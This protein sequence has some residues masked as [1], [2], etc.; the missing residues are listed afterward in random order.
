MPRKIAG[1]EFFNENVAICDHVRPGGLKSLE[2]GDR[3]V[4]ELFIDFLSPCSRVV[5]VGCGA[6]FPGLYVA[7][8]IKKLVGVDAAPNMIAAAQRNAAKVGITNVEFLV[9]S[10]DSLRFGNEEFDGALLCGLLESMDW[11]TVHSTVPEVWR[12]LTSGGRLVVLDRDW[13]NVLKRGP[14]RETDILYEK[15]RLV[16][17]L[18][19]LTVSPHMEKDTRYLVD[20][21][22]SLGQRMMAELGDRTRVPTAIDRDD[23]GPKDV[24]DA[25][26]DEAAQFDAETLRE[27]FASNGFSQV[28]VDS[29]P[30]WDGVLFLT[31]AK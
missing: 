4:A 3:K 14:L 17:R 8:H 15:G 20:P 31:A 24:L 25:W 2:E 28:R 16:L 12:V 22:S 27:L 6:G 1:W 13:Q 9:G 30:V 26:Y 19:E 7:P 11:E 18:V 5:D 29:I 21:N 23:L 10:A